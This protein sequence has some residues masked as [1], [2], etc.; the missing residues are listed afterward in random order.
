LLFDILPSK[1][2]DFGSALAIEN[3]EGKFFGAGILS[4]GHKFGNAYYWIYTNLGHYMDWIKQ[5]IAS[6][7]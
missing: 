4:T 6:N 3:A 1:Q 2:V 7:K 5:T